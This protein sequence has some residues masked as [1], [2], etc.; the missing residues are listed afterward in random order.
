ME[1]TQIN[2]ETPVLEE[3][4]ENAVPDSSAF[5]PAPDE[6]STGGDVSSGTDSLVEVAE[7]EGSDEAEQS[8]NESAI[9]SEAETITETVVQTVE[10][11]PDE[12]IAVYLVD[13]VSLDDGIETYAVSGSPYPGTLNS[14]YLDYFRGIVEKISFME[15]YVAWRS[16]QY[17]YYLVW[18]DDLELNGDEFSGDAL[19]YCRIYQS[20][21]TYSGNYYVEFGTDT[22][23][24]TTGTGFVYSDLG[25]YAALTEGGTH[26]EA[27]T[28]LFAVGFAV[29][30]GVCHDIF[31]YIMERVYRK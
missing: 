21:G 31:D 17:E 3:E 24:L 27:L 2:G 23:Y 1:D 11:L 15:H 22:F 19:N 14:T 30:Y 13:G 8:E 28:L 5:T 4:L 16:G 9:E 20:S 7:G 25:D 12:P 10:V 26:L 6:E 29:V 18:G